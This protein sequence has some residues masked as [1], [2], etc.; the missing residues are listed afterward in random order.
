MFGN[1]CYFYRVTFKSKVNLC[2]NFAW[3]S[4]QNSISMQVFLFFFKQ[5]SAYIYNNLSGIF[6]QDSKINLF[7]NEIL[8]PFLRSFPKYLC[9]FTPIGVGRRPST[10]LFQTNAVL[11]QSAHRVT[12]SVRHIRASWV[13]QTLKLLCI[14]WLSIIMHTHLGHEK[15][16]LIQPSL[17]SN[18]TRLN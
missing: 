17:G 18:E 5:L 6:W 13:V 8:H 2:S 9:K 4:L 7:Y 16:K 10:A 12:W 15:C 11:S 1:Y 14:S 3:F